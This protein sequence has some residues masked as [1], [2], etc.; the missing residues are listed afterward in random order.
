MRARQL[1]DSASYG[2]DQVRILAKAFDDAWT[3]IKDELSDD[4][5]GI[6]AARLKLAKVVL[7]LARSG[8]GNATQLT[9]A[10]VQT[11]YAPPAKLR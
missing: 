4:A 3:Q 1:I 6:E 10:A 11:M 7:C 8:L 2:P 9:Q 5:D